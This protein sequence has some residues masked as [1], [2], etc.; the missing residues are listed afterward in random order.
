[1]EKAEY[2]AIIADPS[3]LLSRSSGAQR[4]REE[5]LEKR[6]K[7]ELPQVN[8]KLRQAVVEYER[9][10]E[11]PLRVMDER[12]LDSLESEEVKPRT[13]KV[14]KP[15]PKPAPA[16]AEVKKMVGGRA[17][18]VVGRAEAAPKIPVR[19][20]ARTESGE[21]AAEVEAAPKKRPTTVASKRESGEN[22]AGEEAAKKKPM[23]LKRESA[24]EGDEAKKRPAFK[25]RRPV[26]GEAVSNEEAPVPIA[27]LKVT[28]ASKAAAARILEAFD[29]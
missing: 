6:V 14:P 3:R 5:K 12:L 16:P 13:A 9:T 1:M 26:L 15:A 10:Y 24:E 21:N 2:E 8:A 25:P 7:K 29:D 17:S 4:L 23:M 18:V 20:V 28:D 19:K 22:A 11:E 27:S